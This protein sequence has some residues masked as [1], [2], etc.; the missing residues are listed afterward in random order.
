MK[1]ENPNLIHES[2]FSHVTGQA[3]YV[4]DMPFSANTLTGLVYTSPHAHARILSIDIKEA[5]AVEGV[6]DII[7]YRAIPG[8][9]QLNPL[10]GDEP[11]L[12]VDT[13]HCIG[14]A[15]LL[16]VAENE[17]AAR[18][19]VRK[20]KID[21]DVLPA[22]ITIEDAMSQGLRLAPARSIERGNVEQELAKCTHQINGTLRIGGQE[23]W[24]L[25]TQSAY[26]VPGEDNEMKVFASSQNPSE[27]QS[28]VA[29]LLGIETHK[30]E[31]EVKR[32]G[33][34][35]GGKETQAAH[36]AAWAALMAKVT[37]RPVK[38][39]FNRDEDQ[40]FT[41]KRHP[42]LASY[43]A[44]FGNDGRLQAYDVELHG[45]AGCAT[46][47]SMAI[48]ERALF[49]A[50]NAYFV[51]HFRVIGTMWRTNL[52][53]NTAFRGFGGPQ[54]AVVIEHTIDQIARFL[55]KDAAEIRK[56]NFYG[57]DVLNETH[58]G[59]LI[60]SNKLQ[61]LWDELYSSSSYEQRRGE[62][63]DFNRTN[64]VVKRGMALTPV[65]FGISF[66][67]SFLN[68]AGALVHIYKDGSVLVNH[69]GTEMGQGLHTKIIQIAAN[70][71]GIPADWVK[72]SAT[73]TSKV[74]NTSPTAA[75]SGTDL[76]GMAVSNAFEIL[77][78][79]LIDVA[80]QLP[81]FA[82]SIDDEI[83]FR[84][85]RVINSSGAAIDFRT[86]AE[87]AWMKQISLSTTAYYATKGLHFDKQAGKGHPFHYFAFGMAV[88]EV[89]LD[90]LTAEVRLLRTDILHDAGK[91]INPAIDKGQVAGAFM[92][93]VGWCTME[94][95]RYSSE[96]K[97]L[98]KSPDTYKI[99]SIADIPADY[100]INL[101]SDA[102]NPDVVKQSKAVG[103][104]PFLLA[105]SVWLAIKDAVSAVGNHLVEPDFHLPANQT[106]ILKSI[107]SVINQ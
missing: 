91:S 83:T 10:A 51:P 15:V 48:L 95:L 38:L 45:N 20:I 26:C 5:L 81:G 33:G 34:G 97:L 25:E 98:N 56:I 52:P 96:G 99:P 40:L 80:K 28:V 63:N 30:V 78:Q 11:C 94:T 53:S 74:P 57:A 18:T 68:Q 70:G 103:E 87:Q 19:A 90:V 79:R 16:V 32:M 73:N 76:N 65:K 1:N 36:I 85:G 93:G 89:E 4:A 12:A 23:H 66:T 67:T 106:Q 37:G 58:F 14:Q 101:L 42:F 77:K 92:Q 55:K 44:G 84:D 86:L 8:H 75:S 39:I 31:C 72:V 107:D 59:Q 105:F 21:Y 27:V 35:F 64:T 71:L 47:L 88:S 29:E 100:R 17:L 13:V 69:G 9:N 50:D 7:D 104:P 41:G 61:R 49:H 60:Q 6:V 24:Y 43:K 102:P 82:L 22:V 46:D 2:A 54:G 3:V 62:I